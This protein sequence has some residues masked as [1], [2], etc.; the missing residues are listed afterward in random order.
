MHALQVDLLCALGKAD[1]KQGGASGQCYM[2]R[3]TLCAGVSTI[4]CG[5]V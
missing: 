5:T 1:M 3:V 4:A 2:S